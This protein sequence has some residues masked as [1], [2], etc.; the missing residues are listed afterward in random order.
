M[1][2][3]KPAATSKA[4]TIKL[5]S[6]RVSDQS[7]EAGTWV[8]LPD[9]P[10]AAVLVRSL[11]YPPYTLART[12]LFQR[13]SRLYGRK[14]APQNEIVPAI[15]K[16]YAEHILLGWKGFDVEFSPEEAMLRLSDWTWR[17]LT[18]MVE[19]AA[20]TLSEAQVEFV[21][22]ATKNSAPPSAGSSSEKA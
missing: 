3:K 22:D 7:E 2:G 6:L 15:G 10:G 5:A 11:D 16:L 13:F 4:A 19:W 17:K 8:D 20:G 21:E 12:V 9:V 1:S 18:T 14:P